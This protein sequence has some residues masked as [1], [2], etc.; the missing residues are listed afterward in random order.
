MAEG[1]LRAAGRESFHVFSAGSNPAGYVHPMA[2]E[3][4]MEIGIDISEHHSKPLEPFLDKGMDIVITVCDHAERAC[5]V[6]P[7]EVSRYHWGFVDPAKTK[8]S[9]PEVLEAFRA[10][11]D[12]IR[13]T[14]EAFAS[15]FREGRQVGRD[16]SRVA[17]PDTSQKD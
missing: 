10:V 14:F 6:F 16:W 8:G 1:I 13:I 15:G 5:P 12:Q 17:G 7:G 2:I 11:R 4:M 9:E 3:V